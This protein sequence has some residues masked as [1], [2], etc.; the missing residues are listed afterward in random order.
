M[1]RFMRSHH[2][3]EYQTLCPGIVD[4]LQEA[5]GAQSNQLLVHLIGLRDLMNKSA[6][7]LTLGLSP[8]GIQSSAAHVSN[9]GPVVQN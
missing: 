7:S 5:V 4:F 9:S 1:H 2:I 8:L 3:C 6:D